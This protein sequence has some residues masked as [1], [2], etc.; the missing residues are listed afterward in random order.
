MAK[1]RGMVGLLALVAGAGCVPRPDPISSE[2]QIGISTEEVSFRHSIGIGYGAP[3]QTVV[4]RNRGGGVLPT[5]A[6]AVRYLEQVGDWLGW[7]LAGDVN[8]YQLKLRPRNPSGPLPVGGYHATVEV[9]CAS[10]GT[11]VIQIDEQVVPKAIVAVPSS[12]QVTAALGGKGWL[13][14]VHVEE[15]LHGELPE[16]AYAISFSG[17]E[18]WLQ[19]GTPFESWSEEEQ[20]RFWDPDLQLVAAGVAKGQYDATL[21]ATSADVGSVNVPVH[22]VV[23]DWGDVP[24][25]SARQC[26]L[27][28]ALADGR[29][30]CAAGRSEL[31]DPATGGWTELP[32]APS[33]LSARLTT[34]LPNGTV[35]VLF[36]DYL[37]NPSC[38]EQAE[39]AVLDPAGGTWLQHGTLPGGQGGTA[40]PLADGRVLLTGRFLASPGEYEP[41]RGS[42]LLDPVHG[43]LTDTSTNMVAPHQHAAA[44]RLADGRVLIAGGVTTSG[45]EPQA[46]IFTPSGEAGRWSSTGPMALARADFTL[47]RL[48]G[49]QVLAAGGSSPWSAAVANAELYDP[50]TGKWSPVG[51]MIAGRSSAGSAVT[52][53]D[54]TI[55]VTGGLDS[56]WKPITRAERYDPVAR[57]WVAWADLPVPRFLHAA[58]LLDGQWVLVFGGSS[59]VLASV[60]RVSYP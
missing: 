28:L 5:P 11:G 58:E 20:T 15:A 24:N 13:E 39:W 10:A 47:V 42:V 51:N 50:A 26:P 41:Y 40:T 36:Q 54:G 56:S 9:D 38:A 23:D 43:T 14:R 46:E 52:L 53:P 12:L 25:G 57:R 59:D 29:I 19:V 16:P 48:P 17:A 35:L 27:P 2:P 32:A 45:Y 33:A 55:L 22:L 1:S 4:I 18:S 7:E 44:V 49:G 30:L 3:E 37:C 6:I 8:S 60:R 31:F 21:V 34:P